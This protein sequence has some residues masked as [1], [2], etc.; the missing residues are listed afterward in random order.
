MIACRATDETYIRIGGKWRYL[1]RA[2]DANSQMADFRVTSRRDDEP[3]SAIDGV[4]GPACGIAMC[5]GGSCE[6]FHR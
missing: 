2:I 3:L 4:D 1:W 6:A 5:Q